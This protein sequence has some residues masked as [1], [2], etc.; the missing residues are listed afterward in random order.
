[1]FTQ[2]RA[3]AGLPGQCKNFCPTATA[4]PSYPFS[5]YAL[6]KCTTTDNRIVR[7]GV[8]GGGRRRQQ[9]TPAK[10]TL[11]QN[12]QLSGGK[13]HQTLYAGSAMQQTSQNVKRKQK[14]SVDLPS[15]LPSGSSY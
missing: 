9:L 8:V 7:A 11:A 12:I 5:D 2:K 1:M 3:T 4:R 15:C 13:G 6:Y 14:P 10:L